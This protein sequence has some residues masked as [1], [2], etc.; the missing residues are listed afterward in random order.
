M[1]RRHFCESCSCHCGSCLSPLEENED[2]HCVVPRGH[3]H[4]LMLIDL[5]ST[6]SS[7][8]LIL[9]NTF[10]VIQLC[11]HRPGSLNDEE[12]DKGLKTTAD[13]FHFEHFICVARA[14]VFLLLRISSKIRA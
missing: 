1:M 12:P 13:N 11:K 9:C 14:C 7:L 6:L 3:N 4:V 10:P 8:F 5:L 2:G